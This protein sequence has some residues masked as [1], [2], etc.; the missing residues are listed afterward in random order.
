ML[1][2]MEST[3]GTP[4]P[5]STR[6]SLTIPRAST[7]RRRNTV[8]PCGHCSKMSRGKSRPLSTGVARCGG[9]ATPF[10]PPP[11]AGTADVRR[12]LR[13]CSALP[14][15]LGGR[16]LLHRWSLDPRLGSDDRR[17]FALDVLR[18][19]AALLR[20]RL[21]LLTRARRW[22]RRRLRFAEIEDPQRAL[23]IAQVDLP[24]H[25]QEDEQQRSVNRNHCGDGAAA[26]AR[27][28]IGPVGHVQSTPAP[29]PRCRCVTMRS[30]V[31]LTDARRSRHGNGVC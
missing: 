2:M 29:A 30:A 21:G 16:N 8:A 7:R 26:V 27:A 17:R 6:H 5:R 19:R 24:G 15:C 20:L 13:R 18:C 3:D 1:H 11:G 28:D 4:V 22:R 10:P 31:R 23:R 12:A 25:V 9:S 14:R